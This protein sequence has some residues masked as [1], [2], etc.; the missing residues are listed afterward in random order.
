MVVE[1]IRH[2]IAS[3]QLNTQITITKMIAFLRD[4]LCRN[5]RTIAMYLQVNIFFMNKFFFKVNMD[6]RGDAGSGCS[7]KDFVV[8]ETVYTYRRR[9]YKNIQFDTAS[10]LN[11]QQHWHTPKMSFSEVIFCQWYETESIYCC[12]INRYV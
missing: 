3:K 5:G 8:I 11:V 12:L 2:G 9:K 10:D 6:I 4:V 1:Y 7:R